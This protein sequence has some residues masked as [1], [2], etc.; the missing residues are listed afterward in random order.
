[1]L[2]ICDSFTYIH[3]YHPSLTKKFSSALVMAATR[4]FVGYECEFVDKVPENYFCEQCRH[5]AREPTIATCCTEV[6][7]KPSL[8]TRT[9]VLAVGAVTLPSRVLT[10]NTKQRS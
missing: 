6:F 9:H 7:C 8:K 3:S 2:S 4:N 1:M 10:R 5:V